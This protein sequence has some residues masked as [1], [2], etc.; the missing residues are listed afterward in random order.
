MFHPNAKLYYHLQLHLPVI[1]IEV[2]K[3]RA[4]DQRIRE[5]KHAWFFYSISVTLQEA[6]ELV[7]L[8]C[9]S[10]LAILS[11]KREESYSTM[12]A[13]ITVPSLFLSR[14]NMNPSGPTP[15][16]PPPPPPYSAYFFPYIK[17][18]SV[19]AYVMHSNNNNK[20]NKT[21]LMISESQINETLNQRIVF[22][23]FFS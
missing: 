12:I 11:I 10:G 1:F 6:W 21:C 14:T 5:V 17:R 18:Y 13:W 9:T 7:P 20:M 19:N 23:L 15:P 22:V 3:Q 16:P 4:Y 2:L 8:P